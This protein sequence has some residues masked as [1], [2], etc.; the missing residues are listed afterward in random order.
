MKDF[1]FNFFDVLRINLISSPFKEA[2]DIECPF[3][4]K[5]KKMNI[6][7][8]KAVAHCWNCG[9]SGGMLK[10]HKDLN[11]LGNNSD[12]LRDINAKLNIHNFSDIKPSKTPI[13]LSEPEISLSLSDRDRKYRLMLSFLSLKDEHRE[14]LKKRG[15]SDRA[16]EHFMFKSLP[17]TT[18]ER[19]EL[20]RKMILNGENVKHLPGFFMG[21]ANDYLLKNFGSGILIPSISLDGKIQGFQIRRDKVKSYLKNGTLHKTAKY[22]CLSTPEMKNGGKMKASTHY[23][24]PFLFDMPDLSKISSLKFTEGLLK[25]DVYYALT[26]EPILGVQGVENVKALKET[27][28]YIIS[29]YPNIKT[30]EDCLDMDYLTN[31]NV[32]RAE[33]KAKTV[34]KALGLEYKR[35]KWNPNEKGIDDF[36]FSRMK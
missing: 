11:G 12:A 19:Y 24:G 17:E 33:E 8:K 36:I 26:N 18:R 34:I 20:A 1:G 9:W 35:V 2:F 15:L 16:I 23:A 27:L 6:N 13:K 4:R 32:L 21:E 28:S 14:M 5:S 3:C 7:A 30:I 25:A 22:I 31:P 29:L 10:F